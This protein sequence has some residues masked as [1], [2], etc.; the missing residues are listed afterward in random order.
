MPLVTQKVNLKDSFQYT[1]LDLEDSGPTSV[2]SYGHQQNFTPTD[3]FTDSS[4]G[5]K[6]GGKLKDNGFKGSDNLDVEDNGPTSVP[7]YNH[8]QQ[9]SPAKPFNQWREGFK[10]KLY[11]GNPNTPDYGFD[12]PYKLDL[13][14]NGPKWT[15]TYVQQ[16][17]PSSKFTQDDE[18]SKGGGKLRHIG[19]DGP[20]QLDIE[21]DPKTFFKKSPSGKQNVGFTQQWGP[22]A[23]EYQG[24]D[25]GEKGIGLFNENNSLAGNLDIEN[26]PPIPASAG[27]NGGTFIQKY[28]PNS[29]FINSPEGDVS[30]EKL[31]DNLDKAK[32]NNAGLAGKDIPAS[33]PSGEV[34]RSF[35][36]SSLDLENPSPNGGPNHAPLNGHTQVYTP[37]NTYMDSPEGQLR[38]NNPAATDKLTGNFRISAL[39]IESTSAG[40]RQGGK[41]GPT[42]VP[43]TTKIGSET[44]TFNT[45]NPYSPYITYTNQWQIRGDIDVSRLRDS[46]K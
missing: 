20:E 31:E 35:V 24:A 23:N 37:K 38:S 40:V 43:Y 1:N 42:N 5:S 26:N 2:S 27:K 16:W 33:F 45:T 11:D 8:Q 32:S 10:G 15:P 25:L 39:D 12:G 36:S 4:E 19:F 44:K 22:N 13:E 3:A 34:Q 18:G 29:Q 41:G 14:N 21:S 46:Y 28:S 17:T 9:W 30:S 7:L 6:T